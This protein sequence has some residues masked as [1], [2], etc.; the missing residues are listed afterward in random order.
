MSMNAFLKRSCPQTAVYWGNPTED[1]DGGKTFSAPV[2]VSCRW[3]ELEQLI[4]D[5]K[6]NEIASRALVYLLQDIDTEGVL[7]LG[8]L[9]TLS[10]AEKTDPRLIDKAYTIKRFEKTPALGSTTVFVR[11]AYLTTSL[12][13]GGL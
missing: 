5:A 8:Y 10:V 7:Y 1:R 6:G 9:S 4:S 3:E 12:S 11:K 13:F 2:E